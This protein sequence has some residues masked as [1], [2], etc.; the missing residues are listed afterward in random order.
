M[1]DP[2][3]SPYSIRSY[4]DRMSAEPGSS[5]RFFVDLEEP[6]ETLVHL[7]VHRL[8]AAPGLLSAEVD[9]GEYVGQR[10]V[11][12]Q[13]SYAVI[14][15]STS[16]DLTQG[17]TLVSYIMSTTPFSGRQS[18]MARWT[19]EDQRGFGLFI[20]TD[21]CVSLR[22]GGGRIISTGKPIEPGVWFLVAGSWDV[23]SG[24]SSV[25]QIP[26]VNPANGTQGPLASIPRVTN[27]GRL[28]GSAD[29][30]S[31]GTPLTLASCWSSRERSDPIFHFNGRIDR[32]AVFGRALSE[33]E[34]NLTPQSWAAVDGVVAS[35]DF[36]QEI[37]NAGIRPFARI[38]DTSMTGGH[39]GELINGPTRG[40][41]GHNWTG[42]RLDFS[43]APEEY[44]AIHFHDDD[45]LDAN[46][47]ETASWL[48]PE[49]APS[50][51]YALIMDH[52]GH[53]SSLPFVVRPA[54]NTKPQAQI[55]LQLP[56]FTYLAYANE[57]MAVDMDLSTAVAGRT[58]VLDTTDLYRH[59]HRTWGG[60]LY[61]VHSDGT[62]ICYA[63]S[64]RPLLNF[65]LPFSD[66]TQ[67][68]Y[69]GPGLSTW[70]LPTDLMILDWL[71]A[72]SFDVDV[73]TDADVH[74]E[75]ASLLDRYRVVLTGSH[76]EYYTEAMWN[77]TSEFLRTGGR[78]M[79]L[80]GNGFYW[81]TA[82]S[83]E[84]PSTIEVRRPPATTSTWKSRPGEHYL[85]FTSEPG[86]LWRHRGR[87]PQKLV[88]VGMIAQSGDRSSYYRR[89]PDSY[90]PSV[91]WAFEGVH[92]EII[93]NFGLAG[94]GAAGLEIDAA[95]ARLGTPAQTF[96]LGSSERHSPAM[97]EVIENLPMTMTH[98]AGNQNPTV[99]A[100]LVLLATESGGG[101]FSA[102][103]I[104][105]ASSLSHNGFRNNVSR[106]TENV[107]RRFAS[108]EPLDI[109]HPG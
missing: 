105:W 22:L 69:G 72:L 35:W 78:L 96:L 86:G 66:L 6:G 70:G 106:I 51:V 95:D 15:S 17:G 50:G 99:R 38:T 75:G 8:G 53:R 82:R 10:Q 9:L 29:V 14:E 27:V 42:R 31:S 62:G 26:V 25:H 46:W 37:T 45:V 30:P 47:N 40:V 102:S 28:L 77:A 57:H 5:L 67:S 32:P 60:S 73:I 76:P 3:A 44:A 80:G 34:L 90:L 48:I 63:S 21:G 36:S 68:R 100:D 49:D 41:T 103:S 13:G 24:I 16:F 43:T 23:E 94:N 55:A 4:S 58:H 87:A 39:H 1:P 19:D 11:T 83:Q 59:S 89:L 12:R 65:H 2:V 71:G 52:D 54:T 84:D 93:G 81:V 18:I 91:S 97:A 33:E 88:G 64:R 74:E 107:L 109:H 56:T 85:S 101:V 108:T 20:E 79:Y 92:E 98:V 61:D 7:Q 104:A